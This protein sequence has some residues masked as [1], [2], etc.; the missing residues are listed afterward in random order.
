MVEPLVSIVIPIY[1]A[2]KYI[3]RCAYSVF[4]QTYKNLDIIFVDDCTPDNSINVLKS[5]I[6][7]FP[8]RE[9]QI[10]IIGHKTNRGSSAARNT[11]LDSAKGSA[12]TFIDA[13]DWI[14]PFFIQSLVEKKEK[15][16]ADI[17]TCYAMVDDDKS[18][19]SFQEPE[20]ASRYELLENILGTWNNHNLWARL[21]DV[22]LFT[23]EAREIEGAN[24]G[25]DWRQLAIIAWN[26][27]SIA[28]VKRYGYH[29]STD[30]AKSYTR[31]I[32][33]HDCWPSSF[34]N[35]LYDN[36]QSICVFFKNKDKHLYKLSMRLTASVCYRAL[37]SSLNKNDEILFYKWRN[38]LLKYKIKDIVSIVG[39]RFYI[40]LLV[41]KCFSFLHN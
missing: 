40:L 9:K 34:S 2:E 35:Q 41:P 7:R 3:V 36:L 6:A 5:V 8:E 13:D 4:Q 33:N 15:T 12:V 30:N 39:I 23:L 37:I 21:I 25:E 27:S 28:I 24:Q 16:G 14:E 32:T 11:G 31:S 38:L 1:K 18:N 26:A 29:Y 22:R 19:L 20:Y 10:R 17:V